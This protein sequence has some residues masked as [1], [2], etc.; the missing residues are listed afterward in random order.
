MTVEIKLSLPQVTVILKICMKYK[1][2]CSSKNVEKFDGEKDGPQSLNWKLL[3]V[4]RNKEA[5]LIS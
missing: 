4:D 2:S 5:N 1:Y 3:F